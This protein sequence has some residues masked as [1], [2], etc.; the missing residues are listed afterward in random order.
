MTDTF[1]EIAPEEAKWIEEDDARAL[2]T[3]EKHGT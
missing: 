1:R 3:F 2:K